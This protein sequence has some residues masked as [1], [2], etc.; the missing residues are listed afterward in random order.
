MSRPA[1]TLMVIE[2]SY[3]AEIIDPR[4]ELPVSRG[5]EGELVLTTLGRTGSPLIRY[6]T[7]DLV[8]EDL[9]I[10]AR[11]GPAR[12]GAQGGRSSAASTTWCS[13]AA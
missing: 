7:G 6:R 11:E 2:S 13:S 3:I 8:R 1:G 9:D 4:G 12:N 10:A 5:E